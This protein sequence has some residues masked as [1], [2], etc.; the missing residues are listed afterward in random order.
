VR[1]TIPTNLGYFRGHFDE[2]PILAGVVQLQ[3]LVLRETR[4]RYPELSV[5]SRLSR[6]KFKRLNSPGEVMDLTLERRSELTVLFSLEVAG[7]PAASG[8][9]TFLP[10]TS[11]VE[12]ADASVRDEAER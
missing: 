6:V 12:T 1:F 9:L 8:L 2:V 11:A 4:L 5:L 3:Q 10:R 7:Q